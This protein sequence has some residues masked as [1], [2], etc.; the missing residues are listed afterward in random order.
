[1]NQDKEASEKEATFL[2]NKLD[3]FSEIEAQIGK[4]PDLKSF[5]E[6][7]L[8]INRKLDLKLRKGNENFR[9]VLKRKEQLETQIEQLRSE[10]ESQKIEI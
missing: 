8:G 5:I 9:R 7:N 2:K 10:I 1:M 4:Q 3:F 6:C